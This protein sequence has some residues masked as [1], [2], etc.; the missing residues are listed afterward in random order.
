[1]KILKIAAAVALSA[2]SLSALAKDPQKVGV[3]D[4]AFTFSSAASGLQSV[5]IGA[6]IE[7]AYSSQA[8]V[9]VGTPHY[10][11]GT[12]GG[13]YVIGTNGGHYVIGTNGGSYVIGTNGGH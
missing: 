6:A 10:V 11:I 2:V 8:S 7:G 12:N 3:A 4:N 9:A 1:M 13:S 5:V